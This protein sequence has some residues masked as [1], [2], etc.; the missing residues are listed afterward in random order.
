MIPS[1]R[2]IRFTMLKMSRTMR[3]A[4]AELGS[5]SMMSFGRAMKAP[6]DDEH[7]HLAPAQGGGELPAALTEDREV[8]EHLADVGGDAGPVAPGV[9]ADPEV[10]LDRHGGIHVLAPG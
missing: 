9:G 2:L 1:L 4:R 5:S 10:L 3:G 7:L 8:V 6:A